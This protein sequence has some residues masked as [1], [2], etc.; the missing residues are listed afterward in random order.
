MKSV[1]AS[2]KEERSNAFALLF[3]AASQEHTAS[4]MFSSSMLA[5]VL[6]GKVNRIVLVTD[7]TERHEKEMLL[8]VASLVP[9]M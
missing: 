1:D 2:Q 7:I 6:Y 8:L 4:R 3:S 5:M 9:S